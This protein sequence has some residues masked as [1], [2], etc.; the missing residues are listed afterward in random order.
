MI[1]VEDLLL[2]FEEPEVLSGTIKEKF[3]I[4]IRL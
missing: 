4:W 2:F 1:G 3:R